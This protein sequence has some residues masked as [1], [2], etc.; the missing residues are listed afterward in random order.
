MTAQR[1]VL[2]AA[3]AL[4]ND[5]V[6][7]R[8]RLHRRP[9]VG[10]DVPETQA[11]VLD[12]LD[13]LGLEVRTGSGLT[14]IVADLVGGRPG[15]TVLLRSDMDALPVREATGLPFASQTDAMHA[16]GH[17]AHMAMLVGAARLLAARREELGGWVRFVFQ[18]GEESFAGAR[19]M[20]DEGLL[21]DGPPPA[22][23]FALHVFPTYP[24]GSVC[25]RPGSMMASSDMVSVT[26]VGRGGHASTPHLALDP[27]PAACEIALAT[28]ALVTRRVDVFDPAV[29]TVGRIDAGTTH[30]VIPE[31]ANLLAT[32]RAFTEETR[33]SVLEGVRRLAGG[34]AG[35]HGL[36]AETVVTPGY[37]VT[38]NDP[39]MARLVLDVAGELFGP[40]RAVEMRNPVPAAEDFSYILQR[41]PGAMV[42]LG[43]R[44]GGEAVPA[45]LHSNRMILDEDALPAGIA[46]HAAL[47]LRALGASPSP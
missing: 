45:M 16:C 29:V 47:A 34:I 12:A 17:D 33:S 5:A 35:A 38:V 24:A 10:L 27:V 21:D 1:S 40:D 8:R 30:N 26:V 42:F 37:P 23:A 7:L 6:D 36:A 44:P 15:P 4:G 14:S 20:L 18:P 22:A 46:L 11:I 3:R 19:I 28:H 43:V 32:V 2:G 25:V 31:R 41:V 9:E 39:A 13:G